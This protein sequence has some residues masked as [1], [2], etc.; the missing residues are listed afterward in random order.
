MTSQ[1][2]PSTPAPWVFESSAIVVRPP[3]YNIELLR[4]QITSFPNAYDRVYQ[5]EWTVDP[6]APES[7]D[8]IRGKAFYEH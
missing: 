7:I 3:R 1:K 2:L 4:R 6:V 5:N 8:N